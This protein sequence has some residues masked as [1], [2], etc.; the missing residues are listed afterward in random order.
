[1]DWANQPDPFRRFEGARS[2]PLARACVGPEPRYEPAFVRGSIEPAQLDA[3]SV[4]QLF[5]DSL[6]LSAWKQSPAARWPLR[7]NPS[8][9]NLHPTEGYLVSGPV[10]GLHDQPG[11]FHYAPLLHALELRAEL[12]PA[13]WSRIEAELPKGAVLVGFSSIYWRESWKYG[14]RAFRYC[15]HDVGHAIGSIAVAA[16]GLGWDTQ[17][18]ESVSDADLAALL[19][20]H[21]QVGV[22]AEHADCLLAVFPQGADSGASVS[23]DFRLDPVSLATL[24]AASW[25]GLTNTLSRD[26][27][28]WPVIGDVVVATEKSAPPG[29]QYWVQGPTEVG[30][31]EP[32]DFGDSPPSLRGVIH[33]RR[34]AVALDGST[35]ITR[36]A[37]Y[38][39]LFKLLPG[40][41]RVPFATLPWRP[42]VDLLLFVHRVGDLAPGLYVLL[43]EPTRRDALEQAM[44]SKFLWVSPVDCPSSL[45]LFLLALGDARR[46]A[47]QVSCNQSIAADGAFAVA[48]LAEYQ[49]PLAANGAWF[50]RRLFWET[51]VI[52]QLL[53]LEAEATGIRGTG[54]GCFF[55]DS[56]HSLFGLDSERFQV[57]YHFAMG[58]AVEDPRLQTR[59]AYEHLAGTSERIAGS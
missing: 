11:I 23:R 57:L 4:S 41:N 50:Y 18:L 19:G 31:L 27:Y 1:L 59:P 58:G 34:S 15:H 9:G 47:Q 30:A 26:H 39:I 46:A 33:Q 16:L 54:I 37:F 38:Q 32:G 36:D 43:R 29:E 5:Y 28:E 6:A 13:A 45:P 48:M 14:E 53:Y 20:T 12:T 10:P 7:V 40:P 56:T 17:L 22:E 35:G 55:D 51:G 2:F 24:D 8:S 25:K 3:N 42:C 52:G 49:E 44:D 21:T